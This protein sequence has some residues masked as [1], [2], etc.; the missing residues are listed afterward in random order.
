MT[1]RRLLLAALACLLSAPPAALGEGG[2][3][4]DRPVR[5]VVPFPAGGSSDIM[6]RIIAQ[7][8]GRQLGQP[9]VVDNRGGAGGA[10]GTELVA[11]AAADGYTLL[12]SGIGSNAIIHGFQSPKPD[13][14]ESDF[15]HIAQI[16]AGPNLLVVNP[17]FPATT[18]AGFIAYL[19]A[20]PGKLNYAQVPAS[21]G[22][23]TMEYLKQV[24]GLDIVAIPY[25]GGG[26]ALAGVLA[27]QVCCM[28]TNQDVVLPHVR[29]GRLR[30]LVLTS[31][32]RNRLYPEIASVAESGYPGFSALSWTGLSAPKGTPKAI[33]ETL[34]AAL[35]K[36]LGEPALRARLESTGFVVVASGS[37]DY[38]A[39]VQAEGAHWARVIRRGGLRPE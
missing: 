31:A 2:A 4:P 7:E 20:N 18:F 33:V 23:L 32:E 35:L 24:A 28:F 8:L 14:A 15:I 21:S 12:L 36:A 26:P 5:L 10:I 37:A 27:N 19:K 11:R 34:E 30:A 6:G 38:S 29:A 1:K 13:Y 22:H 39:F 9:F 3:Y 16:A 25:K 17:Q